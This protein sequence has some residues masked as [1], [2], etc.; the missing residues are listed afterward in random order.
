MGLSPW[1]GYYHY[2]SSSTTFFYKLMS[3]CPLASLSP[4]FDYG[5]LGFIPLSA[6]LVKGLMR[7]GVAGL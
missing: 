2:L 7:A 5:K 6:R 1:Q 3:S 4:L